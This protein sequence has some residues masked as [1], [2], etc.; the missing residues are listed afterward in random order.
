MSYF[1]VRELKL[2][3]NKEKHRPGNLNADKLTE[4]SSLEQILE[5]G[6]NY[7]VD[8]SDL[9][10]H[11][12]EKD[13]RALKEYREKLKTEKEKLEE[14]IYMNI[15]QAELVHLNYFQKYEKCSLQKMN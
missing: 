6:F 13:I 10:D 8:F 9:P 15:K 2:D 7:E 4:T 11:V 14:T 3:L 1:Q 12:Q 5:P